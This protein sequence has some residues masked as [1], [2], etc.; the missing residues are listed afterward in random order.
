MAKR[1][2]QDVDE[3]IQQAAERQRHQWM[4]RRLDAYCLFMIGVALLEM[5]VHLIMAV[6]GAAMGSYCMRAI[7]R[8]GLHM[9]VFWVGLL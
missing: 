4:R 7:L 8:G 3:E 2:I 1:G 5:V 6:G 9:A